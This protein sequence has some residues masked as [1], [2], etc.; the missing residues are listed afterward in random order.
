MEI[1]IRDILA[2]L[3][4]GPRVCSVCVR[5][6]LILAVGDVPADF[7]PD[8]TIDG[9][10][11]LLI[12]GL[13][14]AHTHAYMTVFRNT[15]DDLAFSDWL[16]GR[17]LPREDRL[18]GEDFYWGTLLG[19]LEM[20]SYGVTAFLEMHIGIHD[21][22]RA[23]EESGIRAVLSRGLSGGAAD[24]EGGTRRIR[25]ALEE[26]DRWA[27][28]D[29]IGFM[30]APHAPYTCDEGYLREIAALAKSRDMGIHIHLA[31]SDAEIQQIRE[32]YGC[33]PIELADRCGL[34][35]PHTVAAH[36]VKL[37]DGDIALLAARGVS[38]ATNPVSNLK[39]ANGVAPV[40]KLL[41]AGV[42]VAL[43]TDGSGS[44]N[45]LNPFRELGLV[46]L[47]HKGL[48]GDPRCITAADGF[49]MATKNGA[50]ALGLPGGEIAP[51]MPADLAILNL[52]RPGLQPLGDP[53][54]ALAYSAN[55]SETE[56]VLCAGKIVYDR[57]EYPGIDAERVFYEV[58]R[59]SE[60]IAM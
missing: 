10:G 41:A 30:L 7:R 5:N 35:G 1:L 46:T 13:V 31:E 40:P 16:F 52:D 51:G 36:C 42:N 8:R 49:R 37:T 14:N 4:D 38:V 28:H 19:C 24:P 17:I 39:L 20:L 25:E 53:L 6:G 21:G 12:P 55:G 9:S 59:I 18:T 60:K 48:S 26:A 23:V 56:T 43:G 44:N 45:A 2:V 47:L 27:G 50:R 57:G 22:A 34:L 11:R 58:R 33:T 29:R 54:A 32:A 15:A 3:P